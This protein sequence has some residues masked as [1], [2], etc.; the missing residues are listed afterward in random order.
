LPLALESAQDLGVPMPATAASHQTYA[1][2]VADGLGEKFFIATL[3]ALEDRAGT[4]VPVS[5]S[6]EQP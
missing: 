3:A 4:K 1:D 2:A 6:G 5:R